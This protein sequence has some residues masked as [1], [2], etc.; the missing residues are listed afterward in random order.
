MQ[1]RIFQMLFDK[2]E[3]T[4]QSVIYEL[5]ST[6]QIDPWDVN[7][8]LLTQK[9][10]EMIK[11][12]KE[13]DFKISG[14]VLLASAI[15]LRIKSNKLVGED[16]LE[17]D[18]LIEGS[19][20]DEI[21]GLYDDVSDIGVSRD[22]AHVPL[23]PRTPQPRKRKV[24][25]YDLL[26]ALEKALEVKRRRVMQSLPP[27]SLKAP[28]KTKDVTQIIKDIYTRIRLFFTGSGKNRLLFSN[29]V[30]SGAKEDK[31]YTLIPLLHLTN[32]QKID[33]RQERHFGE[34][35][36]MLKS[37]KEIEKEIGSG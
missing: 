4:W 35:E 7:V 22:N 29:L 30:P 18:R 19:D 1:D 36:I 21:E 37:R 5:I 17:F 27:M 34:I 23:I 3:I 25:I 6:R 11:A 13:L 26:N 31:V 9:Y 24:S 8:S 10:I 28:V 14:K 2:D 15:L 16:I 20:D 32:Q 33:L 12:L